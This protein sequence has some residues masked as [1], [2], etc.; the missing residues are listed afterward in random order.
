MPY[1]PNCNIQVEG[2]TCPRCNMALA[3]AEQ[4]QPQYE[5]QQ[6]YAQPYAA[7]PQQAQYQQS[8]P[9]HAHSP[10]YQQIPQPPQTQQGYPQEASTPRPTQKSKTGPVLVVVIVVLILIFAS[11]AY[12]FAFAPSEEN[13]NGGSSIT[14]E[15]FAN[16]V[17]IDPDTMN[18]QFKSYDDGDVVNVR[19]MV[20]NIRMADVPE[21]TFGVDTGQ[22]TVIF[23]ETSN[24]S[25]WY[26]FAYKGDLRSDYT[27]GEEGIVTLHIKSLS[28]IGIN[29]EYPDEALTATILSSYMEVPSVTLQ[30][31]E[32]SPGNYTGGV[33]SQTGVIYLRDLE[34][35]IY[36]GVDGSYGW[37]DGE[38]ADGN[39]EVINTWGGGLGMT[40]NDVNGNGKL[41]SADV[42]TLRDAE[43][44]DTIE[45]TDSITDSRITLFTLD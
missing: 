14:F 39:P 43:H 38:L 35:E 5:A 31:T 3:G 2:P 13:G 42:I 7:S 4:G 27:V 44:G 6:Q 24:A 17:E 34:I 23:F 30:F 41:D 11:L 36:D 45:L 12:L 33:V 29:A 8:A 15:E 20:D 9:P 37:D 21:G 25:I 10:Q 26:R 19:G 18:L 1:C 16:D 40:Y 22:W 28:I 32:T